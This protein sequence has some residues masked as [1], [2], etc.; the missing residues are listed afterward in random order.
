MEGYEGRVLRAG[1]GASIRSHADS[2][3]AK[4]E[5]VGPS[6]DTSEAYA[7][8]GLSLMFIHVGPEESDFQ[9]L[10]SKINLLLER[11]KEHSTTP[12]SHE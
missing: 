11:F 8:R 9:L 12:S 5:R 10:Q 1:T 3:Q 2:T 6:F 4:D 7:D